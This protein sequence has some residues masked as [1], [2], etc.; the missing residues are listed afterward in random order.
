VRPATTTSAVET[1]GQRVSRKTDV[2]W[3]G[4]LAFAPVPELHHPRYYTAVAEELNF[5]R[6]VPRLHMA[7]PPLSLAI[8]QPER[9]LGAELAPLSV[10]EAT[11]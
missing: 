5:G 3:T 9:E 8:R 4:P 6:A 10:F 11:T 2:V 1:A 7:R